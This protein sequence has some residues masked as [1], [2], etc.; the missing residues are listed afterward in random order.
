MKKIWLLT[1]L[2]VA[3]L[4][5][6]GCFERD[7]PLIQDCLSWDAACTKE[8]EVIDDCAIE[9]WEDGCAVDIDPEEVPEDFD[10]CNRYFDWCN[11][12]TLQDDWEIICTEEACEVYQEAYCGDEQYEEF[13]DAIKS[14]WEQ[15]QGKNNYPE[16][17]PEEANVLDSTDKTMDAEY[18]IN[19]TIWDK[20]FDVVLENNSA[21]RAL[22]E[23]L[24]EWYV[25]I[26]A[27][28]YWWFEK[29]WS[30]WFD[31]PREDKQITTEAW[32]IVLYNWNQISLFYDSNSW[33]YTKLWKVMNK[34][35]LKEA[36]WDW[37][38]TLTFSLKK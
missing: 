27:K 17:E 7:L 13:L 19:L 38:I 6:S 2:L 18:L 30:L 12:W 28:E 10:W 22:Y 16:E 37:D 15:P 26:N 5:L 36:L 35:S 21:T 23:K 1:T 8:I 32:D 14:S 33:S 11:R 31:L 25:V 4:L 20:I 3:G 34:E 9:D 24:K 29:V